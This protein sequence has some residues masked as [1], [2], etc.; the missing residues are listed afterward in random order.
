MAL[1][2]LVWHYQ[3]CVELRSQILDQGKRA[4]KEVAAEVK[5]VKLGPG[6]R[7]IPV[8]LMI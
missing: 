3:K 4:W 2:P 1:T 6:V 7:A 8:A 5:S